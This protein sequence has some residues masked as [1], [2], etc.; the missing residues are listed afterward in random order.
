M[1]TG[2]YTNT[3]GKIYHHPDLMIK[4]LSANRFQLYT[5]ESME[6]VRLWTLRP[7]KRPKLRGDNLLQNLETF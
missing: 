4:M 6:Y 2:K 1:K 5:K 7:G 3:I